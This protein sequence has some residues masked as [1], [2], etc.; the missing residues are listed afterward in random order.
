MEPA[1]RAGF[2]RS[3]SRRGT[4]KRLQAP[5]TSRAPK[6]QTPYGLAM[7]EQEHLEAME[8]WQAARLK[9]V[10]D[11]QKQRLKDIKAT[12]NRSTKEG[13]TCN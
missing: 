10:Y 8:E 3:E 7:A 13:K 9:L 5:P 11:A 6:E 4:Q 12:G 2:D 1:Q